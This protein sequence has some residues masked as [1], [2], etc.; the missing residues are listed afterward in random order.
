MHA[1]NHAT[2]ATPAE[3]GGATE[4]ANNDTPAC[5]A[6][7]TDSIKAGTAANVDV[8]MQDA[9]ALNSDSS[10]AA[11]KRAKLDDQQT[12]ETDATTTAVSVQTDETKS[13]AS[14]Q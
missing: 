2:T 9:D 5:Q 10:T 11:V 14:A 12:Q 6:N 3:N 7:G 1:S 4:K 8:E 13:T